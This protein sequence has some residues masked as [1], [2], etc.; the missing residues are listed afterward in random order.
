[1]C[2][3]FILFSLFTV[4]ALK[5]NFALG[6]SWIIEFCFQNENLWHF[7]QQNT[8]TPSGD[9]TLS[10]NVNV[11]QIRISPESRQCVAAL[12]KQQQAI[13]PTEWDEGHVSSY[14]PSLGKLNSTLTALTSISSRDLTWRGARTRRAMS[15]RT[16]TP[17]SRRWTPSQR[18]V[19]WRRCPPLL[20]RSV[21]ALSVVTLLTTCACLLICLLLNIYIAINIIYTGKFKV[22][23]GLVFYVCCCTSN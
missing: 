16:S 12:Y 8:A 1:M 21:L 11:L 17:S 14:R 23:D 5:S 2:R 18:P 10:S 19:G 15:C 13:I 9:F 4:F 7:L 22:S 6:E 3:Q 20:T